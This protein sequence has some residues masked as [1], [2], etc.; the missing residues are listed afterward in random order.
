MVV[1][2]YVFL[3]LC[4]YMYSYV[5]ICILSCVCIYVFMCMCV[6]VRA[7]MCRDPSLM[8]GITLHHSSTFFIEA[9][10]PT[11][12]QSLPV[13]LVLL[14]SLLYGCPVAKIKN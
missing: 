5:C 14:A 9:S 3:H 12:L 6:C 7:C 10:S 11:Q 2:I 4:V 1:C 8:L 13:W